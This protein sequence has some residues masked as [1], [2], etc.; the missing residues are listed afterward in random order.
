MMKKV[1]YY[2]EDYPALKE[3]QDGIISGMFTSKQHLYRTDETEDEGM[4]TLNEPR[5]QMLAENS[6]RF[7][8]HCDGICAKNKRKS[9]FGADDFYVFRS[10][11][12]SYQTGFDA[13]VHYET[14]FY[15]KSLIPFSTSVSLDIVRSWVPAAER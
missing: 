4:R 1:K 13:K 3:F 11:R 15:L 6:L 10:L 5:R 12:T 8:Q 2:S 9:E 7:E 14:G